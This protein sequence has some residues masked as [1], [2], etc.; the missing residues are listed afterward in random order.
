MV[1]EFAE[2]IRGL[3]SGTYPAFVRRGELCGE[4][5][6]FLYH[7][8]DPEQLDAHFTYLRRNEYTTLHARQHFEALTGNGASVER[9]VVVTFDD[10]L[11]DL[12]EHAFP[13]LC[14][15]KIRAIAFII[16]SRV[17]EQGMV[18]WDHVREMHGSGWV[19]I[20]SHSMHH[21]AIPVLDR[22]EDFFHPTYH[23]YC[24]WDIP[25]AREW[26]KGVPEFPP[27]LGWPIWV[28]G[29]RLGNAPRYFPAEG[30]EHGLAA[31]VA[32]EGGDRFFERHA[33]R[34]VLHGLARETIISRSPKLGGRHETA[35]EQ[36]LS[37][38]AELIESRERIEA[39]V[40]GSQ[41][42]HLAYPWNV[43]GTTTLELLEEC[44]YV[45]AYAGLTPHR[46]SSD[47]RKDLYQLA[48]IS[49]DF[50]PC[51][52]GEGRAGLFPVLRQ[53][54]FRRLTVGRPY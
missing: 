46:R 6:V 38:R 49:G 3:F 22:I 14:R 43:V 27:P 11:A 45:S 15:H 7:R 42:H 9:S 5:P 39:E 40:P 23:L 17:G 31:R 8:I 12:Y 48:R 20:E 29:S 24:P 44:G 16:P 35:E 25:V 26:S 53:K 21:A 18:T 32:S 10:G 52:P 50:V 1:G 51:L 19:D 4:L 41:V 37:I 30:V 13:L 28:H 2:L 47:D 34:A 33:W 54:I 36:R